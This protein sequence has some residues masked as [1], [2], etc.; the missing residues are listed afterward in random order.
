MYL[1]VHDTPGG[2]QYVAHLNRE[3]VVSLIRNLTTALNSDYDADNF[4]ISLGHP[5][6][7]E[8]EE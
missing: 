3:E 6:S 2:D 1:K 4:A 8:E 5:V 7:T